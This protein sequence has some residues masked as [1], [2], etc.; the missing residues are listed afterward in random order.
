MAGWDRRIKR[1]I[2][3]IAFLMLLIMTGCSN[4][5]QNVDSSGNQNISDSGSISIK[6]DGIDGEIQCDLEQLAKDKNNTYQHIYSTINNWPTK[7]FYAA[8]GIKISS[9]LDYADVSDLVETVT[10]R[11]DDGY[12]CTL[13]KEQLEAERYYFPNIESDSEEGAEPTEAIIA[14][15]LYADSQDLSQVEKTN[16]CFIL[17]QSNISEHTNPAFVENVSEIIVSSKDP[18]QWEPPT[19]FPKQGMISEG[20][21]VKLE[22]PEIGLVKIYYT[23]DGSEPTDKSIMYNPSTYQ[24]DLNLPILIHGATTIKAKAIGYGKKDSPVSVFQYQTE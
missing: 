11:S 22:H 17:G 14:T 2:V 18:G 15:A 5:N 21:T 4:T 1:K 10:I 20:D 8:Q 9:I 23:L 16:P 13:T 24:P 6:G 12:E 19:V 3:L 7:K